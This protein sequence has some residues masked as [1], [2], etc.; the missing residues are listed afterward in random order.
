MIKEAD[1]E[2]PILFEKFPNLRKKIGWVCLGSFP[3]PVHQIKTLDHTNLWIK[4]DDMSSVFYGGNKV[5]KLEFIIGDVFRKKKKRV[6]TIGGIG[7]NHGLATA[8]FCDQLGISCSLSLFYQPVTRYVKQN[9]L[10]FHKYHAD[11]QYKKSMLGAGLDFYL[12]KKLEHPCAYLIP[13]GGSSVLGTLGFVNAAFELKNQID[14]GLLPE[15]EYIFCALGSCG[16]MA[17]LSLGCILAGLKTT[18]I[19]VRVAASNLG[20]IPIASP[21]AVTTLMKKTYSL[22]KKQGHNIPKLN[23]PSPRILDNYFGKG[24][25]YPTREGLISLKILK[26]REDISL[27]P[28]YTSKTFAAVM[29]FIKDH[30]GTP[31]LFWNTYNS[32]DLSDQAN[33][34]NYHDLPKNFH[35]FFEQK[36]VP[37]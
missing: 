13:A 27:D 24:Y 12:T 37:T 15:P 2:K 5:R 34:V 8:V 36:E 11:M 7:T 23:L 20:P 26:A 21:F 3:T 22:L 35:Q 30:P 31:T 10:L 28:T 6:I 18:V 9:M 1:K 14:E 16:T 33:T 17:G 19:G 29:D 4:R 25:G 32:V